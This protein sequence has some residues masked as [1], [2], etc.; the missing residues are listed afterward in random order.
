MIDI[1]DFRTYNDTFGCSEI[2]ALGVFVNRHKNSFKN[3][4]DLSKMHG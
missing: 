2:D 3:I 4:L 1:G